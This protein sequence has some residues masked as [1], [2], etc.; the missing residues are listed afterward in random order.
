MRR[1]DLMRRREMMRRRKETRRMIRIQA[2]ILNPVTTTIA[3]WSMSV[4]RTLR[5]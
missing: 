5:S 4:V 2:T 1:R 3:F